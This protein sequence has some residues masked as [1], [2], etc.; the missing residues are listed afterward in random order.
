[1]FSTDIKIK[2]YLKTKLATRFDIE[3]SEISV[4]LFHRTNNSQLFKVIFNN[5]VL[6]IKQV[7][8]ND[9]EQQCQ[10]MK[11][12]GD[13]FNF[14]RYKVP[15]LYDCYQKEKILVMSFV[16][17]SDLSV[18]L[19]SAGH[20]NEKY[21]TVEEAGRWIAHYHQLFA[22]DQR[23]YDVGSK[24]L[25]LYESFP[26]SHTRIWKSGVARSA[27]EW[28]QNNQESVSS[29]ACM[30][31]G[32]H[33]DYKPENLIYSDNNYFGIDYILSDENG[34]QLMDLAQFCNHLLFICL[35]ARGFRV[36]LRRNLLIRYFLSAY[37]ASRGEF[38]GKMLRWLRV[39]HL[40]RHYLA[41][42]SKSSLISKIQ[43]AYLAREIRLLIG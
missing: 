25:S 10:S 13:V 32:Y 39:E 4:Q 20:P 14:D 33:G 42:K 40:L 27:L 5:R 21:K 24:L 31:G 12:V 1:M 11:A 35:N 28:L 3:P 15:T 2:P 6:L 19:L 16:E 9:F 37:Q 34:C 29:S 17:G 7:L 23:Q 41:E 26:L 8:S 22:N 30:C 38:S 18:S 36:Y 43:A